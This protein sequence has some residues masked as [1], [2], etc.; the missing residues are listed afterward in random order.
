[1]EVKRPAGRKSQELSLL[2]LV[3]CLGLP[4]LCGS[5]SKS[6][7]A[8]QSLRAQRALDF[9]R[10]S[11]SNQPFDFKILQEFND[12]ANLFVVAEITSRVKWPLDEV[13]VHLAT[14]KDGEIVKEL[15]QSLRQ[16]LGSEV[17]PFESDMLKAGEVRKFSLSVPSSGMSDY[18]LELLWGEEAQ[19][20][21]RA[22]G[23]QQAIELREINFQR[24]NCLSDSCPL[25][26]EVRCQIVN[27]GNRLVNIVH[28]GTAWS[29]IN[30]SDGLVV[31]SEIQE[32]VVTLRGLALKPGS[33]RE[34]KVKIS[35][36]LPQGADPA[37]AQRYKPEI[38][39]I[40][41]EG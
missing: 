14:R 34:L 9:A 35:A 15:G 6:I 16:A 38:R 27:A 32:E 18:Q 20:Y 19:P 28:L 23:Q 8:P 29:S 1:M 10:S 26:Y 25:E 2:R 3:F 37:L 22:F 11:R 40:S 7:Q 4:L 5:C 41:Y 24:V 33:A 36:V 13:A 30:P 31:E 17:K 21:L 39:I 12:G